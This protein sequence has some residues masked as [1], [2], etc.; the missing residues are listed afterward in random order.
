MKKLLWVLGL[1]GMVA[2]SRKECDL[3]SQLRSRAGAGAVDCGYAVLNGNPQPVDGC[4]LDSFAA[5]VAFVAR[6]DRQ[7]IDSKVVFGIA[8]DTQGVVT[9]LLWDSDPSGGSGADPV[10][11]GTNCVG[12]A[13]DLSANRNSYTTPPL[14]CTSS[15]SLGQTCG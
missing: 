3:V 7:G 6:Y 8:G 11:S 15:A 13:P 14:T 10:V 2:C 4:V 12:P 5:K 9:F 1:L